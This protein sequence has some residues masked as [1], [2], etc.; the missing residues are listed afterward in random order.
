MPM[1]SFRTWYQLIPGY[2]ISESIALKVIEK[3]MSNNPAESAEAPAA[4]PLA[5]AIPTG[6]RGTTLST[7]SVAPSAAPSPPTTIT[8]LLGLR[9]KKRHWAGAR[10]FW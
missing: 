6:N 4:G 7:S 10:G 8:P 9:W 5:Q 3:S 1:L 2:G